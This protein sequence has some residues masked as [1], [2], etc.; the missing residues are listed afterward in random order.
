MIQADSLGSFVERIESAVKHEAQSKM[1][2]VVEKA[3]KEAS[4][5]IM[6]EMMARIGEI[7]SVHIVQ[8]P[9]SYGVDVRVVY[10]WDN[11]K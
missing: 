6:P 1:K 2:E 7:V 9:N 4:E 8:M 3:V 10:R 5:K 11:G